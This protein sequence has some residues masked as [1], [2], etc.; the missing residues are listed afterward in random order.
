MGSVEPKVCVVLN[1]YARPGWLREAAESVLAQDWPNFE[2]V[3]ADDCSPGE[4]TQKAVGKILGKAGLMPAGGVWPEDIGNPPESFVPLSS[5]VRCIR[6]PRNYGSVTRGRNDAILSTDADY[7]CFLDDDNVMRP[8]GLRARVEW[9]EA[10]PDFGMVWAGAEGLRDGRGTG[11]LWVD[12]PKVYDRGF[13]LRRPYIDSNTVMLRREVFDSVGLFDERLKTL[14]DWDMTLRVGLCHQVGYLD[15]AVVDYRFHA[16]N[17]VQQTM[18]LNA[19]SAQ[20]MQRKVAAEGPRYRVL[21][22]RPVGDD[23][24]IC[25]SHF[26]VMDYMMRALRGLWWC[27]AWEVSGAQDPATYGLPREPNLVV[28]FYPARQELRAWEWATRAGIPTWGLCCEDPFAEPMNLPVVGRLDFFGSN[29]QGSVDRYRAKGNAGAFLFPALSAAPPIHRW[30]KE[31]PD[32]SHDCDAAI[33]GAPY[34]RRIEA[35]MVLARLGASR[36]IRA[37]AVGDG[38]QDYRL[39]G[40]Q[41]VPRNVD[42][43]EFARWCSGAKVTVITNRDNAAGR[44][45]PR[46]PARGFAEAACGAC[47]L[48]D[49]SR[50]DLAGWFEDGV[51]VETWHGCD[52]LHEKLVALLEDPDRREKMKEAAYRRAVSAYTYAA[53]L[54]RAFG[55]I[56]GWRRGDDI[57]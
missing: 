30:R 28:V 6:Q 51:E 32:G 24:S 23:R 11:R 8:D 56:R 45:A 33:V 49:D 13:L 39:T 55:M 10:N 44:L 42:G 18:H 14:E 4:E 15:E 16:G 21:F 27:D 43:E 34:H 53:R 57:R 29:D 7:I 5:R 37:V 19:E 31:P 3:I 2:L 52:D 36:G 22:V 20:V 41:V 26:Q 46:T 9:L 17:R 38:W 25:H 40:L 50:A 47:I 12:E 1:T 35:A 54:T 48:M